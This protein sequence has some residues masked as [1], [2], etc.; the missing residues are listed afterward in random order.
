MTSFLS[1]SQNKKSLF[2]P[3]PRT[4]NPAKIT[5]NFRT[6]IAIVSDHQLRKIMITIDLDEDKEHNLKLIKAALLNSILP[7]FKVKIPIEFQLV[8]S[9][10][11]EKVTKFYKLN[12]YDTKQL[13]N[14]MVQMILRKNR[15]MHIVLS[16]FRFGTLLKQY[17]PGVL[18]FNKKDIRIMFS[19][20]NFDVNE[21]LK[22]KGPI[23]GNITVRFYP[24]GGNCTGLACRRKFYDVFVFHRLG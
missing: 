10:C 7:A 13:M 9:E 15:L 8:A 6:K 3:S 16:D 1:S 12:Q 22:V 17:S 18:Y 20:S 14:V 24:K 2:H 23:G 4:T 11:I 5:I 19:D 21:H